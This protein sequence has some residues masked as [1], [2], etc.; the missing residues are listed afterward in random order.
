ML[1]RSKIWVLFLLFFFASCASLEKYNAQVD[2]LKSSK[3]LKK[4]IVYIQRKLVKL[5]PDLNHYI[6]QS[7]LNFKFDSLRTTITDSMSSNEFFFKLSPVIAAIKQG[8]TQT[9]PLRKKFNSKDTKKLNAK[10]FSPLVRFEYELF[11]NE[12]YIVK[13]NSNDSTIKPGTKILSVNGVQPNNIFTKYQN[14]FTSD[15]YNSTYIPKR[16]AKGFPGFFY[17]EIGVVDSVLCSLSYNDSTF[18]ATLKSNKPVT[19]QKKTKTKQQLAQEKEVKKKEEKIKKLQGY[20]SF[21]RKYSKQL[22]FHN[23][24]SNIAILKIADFTKGNYSKFYRNTFKLLDSLQTNTL[25]IDLRDNG[26]GR[27]SE[28]SRLYSYLTDSTF[29]FVEKSEVTSKTSLWHDGFFSSKPFLKSPF[30]ILAIPSVLLK[31][32]VTTIITVKGKDDKYRIDLLSSWKKKSHRYRFDGNV[33]V[34]INGGSFSASSL[35]AS[36]LQGSKRATFVGEETGGANNGCVAGIMPIQELP[37]SKL[38]VR[39]GLLVC[40]TPYKAKVDGRGVFPNVEISPIL[41]DRIN[42]VDPELKWVINNIKTK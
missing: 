10:G 18:H 2:T 37:N 25:I 28:V 7:D 30:K 16:L 24:D 1:S 40:Q 32:I 26:G 20:D 8:H 15:G 36:N 19:K 21:K 41:N 12:L 13:N 17:F 9:Y 42:S 27:L 29:R 3:E 33:Y 39:F 6:T 35:I 4:D 34:L 11:N 22:V 38:K 23:N 31:N 5:H 14:T